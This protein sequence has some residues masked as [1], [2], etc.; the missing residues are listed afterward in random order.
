MRILLIH[1]P[2]TI[3]RRFLAQAEP[4][5]LGLASVA[6]SCRARGH[7]VGILDAHIEGFSNRRREGQYVHVG[8]SQDAIARRI[9]AFAPDLIGISCPFTV[10][11]HNAVDVA[12]TARR[13]APQA[14]LVGG[15]AHVTALPQTFE[16][17]TVDLLVRG[18]GELAFADLADHSPHGNGAALP[19]GVL[20]CGE[21]VESSPELADPPDLESLPGP[22][23]DL[24]ALPLYWRKRRYAKVVTTRGC[25]FTCSF[26]SVHVTLGREVRK[27]SIDAVVEELCRLRRTY[28]VEEVD[29][30]DDNLTAHMAWAKELF[31]RIAQASPGIRLF[32]RDGVRADRVDRELLQ[33]M[34]CA[35]VVGVTFAPESGC[36]EVLDEVIGKRMRLEQV[37]Q[38][39]RLACDVGLDVTCFLVIGFPRESLQQVHRTIAYGH[40]LRRL[41]ANRIWMSCAAPHPGTALWEE[42]RERGLVS[43]DMDLRL[44]RD[45][46]AIIRTGTFTPEEIGRLRDRA[47]RAY[48][49][50]RARTFLT[51]GLR[52]AV[53]DPGR[54]ARRV[55]QML[56]PWRPEPIGPMDSR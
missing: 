29:L 7:A 49:P 50:S 35:G 51:N 9:Q 39:V 15:G 20:R 31:E 1:P 55:G 21:A 8:L 22:A 46:P 52:T 24:L 48:H 37:E 47:M 13:V 17:G 34:K 53:T 18:E 2:A 42:C 44:V 6:A 40:R 41:G 26:C 33:L 16:P 36:Q 25:P 27:R 45:P 5:P 23:Y 11:F 28:G 54:F 43:E 38:A 19:R 30:E 32:L 10:Q 12:R 14:L 56:R 3:H 4:F